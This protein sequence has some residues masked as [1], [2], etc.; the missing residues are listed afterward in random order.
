[1]R[2]QADEYQIIIE[3]KLKLKERRGVEGIDFM[4]TQRNEERKRRYGVY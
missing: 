4:L 2:R 3:S 1:M